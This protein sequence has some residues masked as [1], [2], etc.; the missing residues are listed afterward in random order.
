M[1]RLF[2]LLLF[3]IVQASIALAL[4]HG[5]HVHEHLH[6]HYQ[7]AASSGVP[8][9]VSSASLPHSSTSIGH[10]SNHT[11]FG[12]SDAAL[13]VSRALKALAVVNKFRYENINYNKY[14]FTDPKKTTGKR[15]TAPP[16]D[17]STESVQKLYSMEAAYGDLS[18]NGS[19]KE[20]RDNTTKAAPKSLAYTISPELAEAAR[21][22]AE[23]A[24]PSPS[25]GKESALAAAMQAKYGQNGNDTNMAAQV[26]RGPNGLVEYAPFNSDETLFPVSSQ[27]LHKRAASG[28]QFWM[29][30][31]EQRGVSPFA[32]DGYKV[33]RNVKDYGAKGD[34]ITDDTVAINKAISDGGRCGADCGSSTIYPAVVFFPPG[35]YLVSSS[36]IQYYNTQFLGDPTD[37]PTILAAASFVGLGVITSDV[38]VGDQEEW[39]INTNNFLRN[40]RNFK[41]DITRTD[42]MAYVCAIHWQVAQGTTLEN[43][44][45][46][47]AQDQE[48]TQQG[49][50]MENGSGGFMSNL[51]FVGGNFGAYLGNQQFT[52]NHL[53]FVNCK[54]ALQIHWDW[55][56][57][58]QDVVIESCG[59][60]IVVTGGAGGPMSNGQGVGSL[61]LVDALIA[62][63]PTGIITSLY[64]KNS[65]A[66][67]LQNVGFYNVEKAIMAERFTDPILAGGNEVL[68]DAW[69]FGL[70]AQDYDVQFA[71]QRNLPAMQRSESLTGSTVYNKGTPNF[72]VRRRPQYF[73]IGHSQVFDVKAYGARGDGKTDDTA[74]LNSILST[75]ANMSSIVYF[76]YGIYVVKDTLNIPK[77]SRIVGQAWSQIMATG[78]KF[79]DAENPHVAV[80]VGEEGDVGIV[81][82]QDMMFT[83]SGPTAGAVLMEWNVHESTQGSA[84]LWDSHFRV[85]GAKGSNLQAADCPKQPANINKNCIAASLL[86]RITKSASAYMENVWAWTADHDLDIT[87]QDQVDIYSARGIL[88]ESQGPTWMY[89]TSCEHNVLYQYQLSG[90]QNLVMGMIQ[91]ESPYFQPT[92]LRQSHSSQ[93]RSLTIRTFPAAMIIK[94][95]ALYLGQLESSTLVLCLYSWFSSYSQKCLDT[96]DCQDSAFYVEQTND[97]WVFNLVTK[98]IVK[99]ITPLGHLPL[100]SRDV[101]NGYT[102]SLLAWLFTKQEMI[103][104]RK[105]DGFYLYDSTWDED[106]LSS[107]SSVCKTAMTRLIECHEQT[108]MLSELQWRAGL[109]ND[110]LTDLVCEKTCGESIEA[111]FESV[112]LNCA[113]YHQDDV[114]LT[115]PGGI[116]WAGWNETCVKDPDTGKYCGDVINDFTVVNTIDDMPTDE[117]CSYCYV[118]RYEMMQ[119]TSYSIYDETYQSDLI[120]MNSKCDLSAPTDIPPPIEEPA[121]PY[122]NNLT[123]CASDTIYTTVSGDTCD[124]IALKHSVSS[125]ALFIGNPNL[126]N[127]KDIPAGIELC[128]PFTC[129]P[130]YTL[131]DGDTCV[132][133]EKSLGLDYAAGYNVRKYNPWLTRDCSNLQEASNEVYGKVLCGAPQGGT[134]TGT[135]PPVGVTSLPQT[136]DDTESPPPT[137]ATVPEGTTLRCARWH[138]VA[139]QEAKE[140]CTK[141]CVKE[142]IDWELF[143]KA[144]PSLTIGVCDEKLVVG[145]AYCVGP[146]AGFDS[147]YSNSGDDEAS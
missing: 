89:G 75:A 49:I 29:A 117:L 70:Y 147:N 129:E 96:E 16:L 86:L 141:I 48:T 17:Y 144:N 54:T 31:I 105:F 33:W 65:T 88:I 108:Y 106:L 101:R 41:I 78:S 77:G 83:V 4:S 1:R 82:I 131:K 133:I 109:Q 60:G 53:V 102:A 35:T 124:T 8:S 64:S 91:T 66:F 20:K 107:V 120:F 10:S 100:W 45:F 143:L 111:W 130:T 32:P 138:V 104:K 87:S 145:N 116:L 115:K 39:Y 24:P 13:K 80:K 127:C 12:T 50:Y 56:W 137:N 67:L 119:S 113:D 14:E 3:L 28:S 126:F 135:A 118:K 38:Y 140:T 69:G 11:S 136:G 125:A 44:E 25:T 93:E 5:H 15:V 74:V 72:F 103:G 59:T 123:F 112:T 132:S 142:S 94:S 68:I 47:M 63:T 76:P 2:S 7:R 97:L 139:D 6:R 18:N 27:S 40:V 114:V 134:S 73:D 23:S 92:P 71:Q 26:L 98:A 128:L 22:L 110:T 55:A 30:N 81:E 121:N 19:M 146:I 36:I 58:M 85:G 62:N 95:G 37:Y 9:P 52:S 42:P 84:G 99:S 79:Q 21:I 90:A 122:A 61:I 46:Y 34:G 43:I 57:T 51:T